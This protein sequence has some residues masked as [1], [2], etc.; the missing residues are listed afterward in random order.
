MRVLI[1]DD[2]P[3]ARARMAQQLRGIDGYEVIGEAGNGVQ[4]IEKSES[5]QADILLLDIRMPGMDGLEAGRHLSRLENPPAVI[6]TTAY[7]EHA[8]EAFETHAVAYLLKPVRGEQLSAA[9][10]QAQKLTRAQIDKVGRQLGNGRQHICARARG[11]L[12][13]IAVNDIYY[14]KADSKYVEVRH[15][16]G[17]VLIEESLTAL[18]ADFAEGFARAHRNALVAKARIGALKKG[19]GGGGVVSFNGI[20]DEVEVSRRHLPAIRALFKSGKT[21]R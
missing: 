6:F 15:S 20:A 1:V 13:L 10:R 5:L 8:L 17:M 11:N 7:N 4:A 9:L 18:E 14:F 19:D 16:D 21:P 12:Q 2:E 3:L